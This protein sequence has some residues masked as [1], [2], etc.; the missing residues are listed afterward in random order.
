MQYIQS[1][2]GPKVG[3]TPYWRC[4]LGGH[5]WCTLAVHIG[6]TKKNKVV[7]IGTKKKHRAVHIANKE[8]HIVVHIGNTHG[9]HW[10]NNSKTHGFYTKTPM[11]TTTHATVHHAP[12]QCAP[13]GTP[14]CAPSGGPNVHPMRGAITAELI[15][16][17][18]PNKNK[19]DAQH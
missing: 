17:T 11:C 14:Q 9:A 7:R 2:H 4:T 19:I 1:V 5:R 3:K 16:N 10:E 6:N 13:S 18:K 12:P 15:T 8:K